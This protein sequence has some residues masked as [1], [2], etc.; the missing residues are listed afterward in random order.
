MDPAPIKTPVRAPPMRAAG[1]GPGQLL[2]PG[3]AGV[4]AEPPVP[5]LAGRGIYPPSIL[6]G[7]QD[8]G[9]AA[10]ATPC[11]GSQAGAAPVAEHGVNGRLSQAAL[12]PESPGAQA[13]SLSAQRP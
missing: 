13:L 3:G 10:P 4:G 2:L 5:A 8:D 12:E 1:P 9:V 6:R 7:A 11:G